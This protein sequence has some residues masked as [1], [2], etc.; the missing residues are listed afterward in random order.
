MA[1]VRKFIKWAKFST[2]SGAIRAIDVPK[3]GPNLYF[4]TS[5]PKLSLDK[6]LGEL[7]LAFSVQTLMLPTVAFDVPATSESESAKMMA[8]VFSNFIACVLSVLASTD[9]L[10]KAIIGLVISAMIARACLVL[11]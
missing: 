9:N 7:K 3:L 4:A 2:L 5:S 10:G 1:V 6:A 8:V 11:A